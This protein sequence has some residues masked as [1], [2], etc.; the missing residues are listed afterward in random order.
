[1]ARLAGLLMLVV[2]IGGLWLV[3]QAPSVPL[4]L[5]M[6]QQTRYAQSEETPASLRERP[7]SSPGPTLT[8]KPPPAPREREKH[9]SMSHPITLTVVYDN[10]PFD[11][12][13]KTAWGFACLVET[14]KATVLFDTGGDGPT[15]MSNL[16]TLGID[17][18]RIDIVFL[19]HYHA[20]HT[21]GLNTLLD[22]AD[23]H[24]VYVPR[25]FPSD[26][27]EQVAKRVRQTVEVHD[28]LM[29][30]DRFHTM[31]E[32]GTGIIEQSLIVETSK[33]LIVMTGCA[34]PG[35]VEIVRQARK[36]GEVYLAIGGFHLMNEGAGSLKNVVAALKELGV[37]KVAPCHCTGDAARQLFSVEFGTNFIPTGAGTIITET[38]AFLDR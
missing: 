14:D 1:M 7:A 35:I 38:E 3:H 17:P 34:H 26:F 10:N 12:R 33:G 32:I 27:K 37:Q 16:D 13:L 22:F 24:A 36:Y 5:L 30:S 25:S 8:E 18:R 19:S 9:A 29:I 21:G 23:P 11:A 20:D 2:C 15:L 31:G 6:E 4:L 28:P